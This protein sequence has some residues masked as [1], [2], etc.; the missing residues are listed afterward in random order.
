[1]RLP[2]RPSDGGPDNY[3]SG[4]YFTESLPCEA[5]GKPTEERSPA[6]DLMVCPDCAEE[7]IALMYAEKTCQS[8]HDA[9]IRSTSIGQVRK[10]MTEH[11]ASCSVCGFRIVAKGPVN[12]VAAPVPPSKE[13]A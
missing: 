5:C 10:A 3:D 13:A 6:D 2:S 8:L 11:K 7:Y 12:S 1:M 9:I 4:P